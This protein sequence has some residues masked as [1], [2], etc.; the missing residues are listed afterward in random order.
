MPDGSLE[1]A[2]AMP[3][4]FARLP[5][6]ILGGLTAEQR[7]SIASAAGQPGW[8]DH[9]INIRISVP[10]LPTRW[11]VTIVGG[12][13]RRASARRRADRVRNPLCTAGNFAFVLLAAILFYGLAAAAMLISSSTIEY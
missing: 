13:E 11:Y 2:A 3:D 10:F 1:P 12:P 5:P 6:H 9:P 8:S 7:R 4:L